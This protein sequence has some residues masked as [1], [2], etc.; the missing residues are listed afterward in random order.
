M[1]GGTC[2]LTEFCVLLF[3]QCYCTVLEHWVSAKLCGMVQ[4]MELW[5]FRS[6]PLSTEGA[7]YILRAAITFGIGPHSSFFFAY[8]QR[9]QIGCY[10]KLLI[11]TWCGL[12]ANLEC[13][14]EMCCTWLAENKERKNYA[15]F[16]HLRTIA[17]L[18]RA[19]CSQRRDACI[20]NRKKTVNLLF[21]AALCNR[22]GHIYFHPVISFY[23]SIFF[24]FL[25]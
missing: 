3:W 10:H 5:N 8:S 1:F 25:A 4:K 19:I 12:S 23:L 9:P 2:H 6:S 14:S 16:R 11:H 21:M 18:C 7:T 22:A 17:Q 15:K 24:L 13:R 20:D